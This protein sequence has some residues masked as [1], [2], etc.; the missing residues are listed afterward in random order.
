MSQHS[1]KKEQNAKKWA[2]IIAKAWM[3]PKFK[4]HLLE[5]PAQ[6]LKENGISIKDKECEIVE[7]TNQKFY[8]V[9][10][11][12]PA[13]QLSETDLRDVA[14]AWECDPSDAVKG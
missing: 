13:N 11:Q 8:L 5:N 14:A 4:K 6:V 10:P 7:N 3:D 1:P 9:L 12:K 2:Q